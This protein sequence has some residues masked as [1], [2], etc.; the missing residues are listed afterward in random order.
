MFSPSEPLAAVPSNKSWQFRD[1]NY[2]INITASQLFYYGI[3]KTI[4]IT[5]T[6]ADRNGNKTPTF[7]RIFNQPVGPWLIP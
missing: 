4:T 5:G 7:T 2:D 6:V 3:E 1:K